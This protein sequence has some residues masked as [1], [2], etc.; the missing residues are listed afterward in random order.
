[1][2]ILLPVKTINVEIV[3]LSP[4]HTTCA[5]AML[6]LSLFLSISSFPLPCSNTVVDSS[7]ITIV[8]HYGVCYKLHV[9]R[10]GDAK[11]AGLI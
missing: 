4:S 1:M 5:F 10:S 3:F 9:C 8:I 11:G 7:Q 2:S 6:F